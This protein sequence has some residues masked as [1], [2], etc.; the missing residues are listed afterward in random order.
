M[1]KDV[2][3]TERLQIKNFF[4]VEDFDW[5]IKDVNVITGGI[6]AG[7]SLCIKLA[8]FFESIL[9]KIISFADKGVFTRQ[10]VY[11]RITEEFNKIFHSQN[12]EH[13][14]R[15]TI[16][17][18]TFTV[19][20]SSLKFDLSAKWDKNTGGLKWHSIYI[21][22]H[23]AQWRNKIKSQ[24]KKDIDA[25]RRTILKDVTGE[26][27]NCFPIMTVFLPTTR[28]I[29]SVVN[30][31]KTDNTITQDIFLNEFILSTNFN[32]WM[33]DNEKLSNTNM[34]LRPYKLSVSIKEDKKAV[35]KELVFR[36]TGKNKREI[37]PLEMSSG[38]QE[39]IFLLLIMNSLYESSYFRYDGKINFFSFNNFS[40]FIEEP[41]THL[42]PQEQKTTIEFIVNI[43]RMLKDSSN[44]KPRFFITTHSPYTLNVINNILF[45]G[46]II[47][48]HPDQLKNINKKIRFPHLFHDEISACFINDKEKYD[49]TKKQCRDMMN[50]AEGLMSADEIVDISFIINNDT[51]DLRSLNSELL[52]VKEKR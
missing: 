6:A 21:N 44:K 35:P 28:A 39:V 5:I 26:F 32:F 24:N 40:L 2:V 19:S 36:T 16:I 50:K 1:Q 20:E 52:D 27:H 30:T 22:E 49:G 4:S 25:V 48:D 23:I 42:F 47:K 51:N 14:Y 29:A 7:K 33:T 46:K 12:H 38:Q 18:Y 17:K 9:H 45:K 41:S 15:D 37:T 3:I 11:A 31:S 13:D 10:L 8:Y 43:F 34:I